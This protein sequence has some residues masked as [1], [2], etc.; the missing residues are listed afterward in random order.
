VSRDGRVSVP[1]SLWRL[2][3]AA[4]L[5]S[6][7]DAATLISVSISLAIWR[8]H[9]RLSLWEVGLLTAGL[10]LAVAVGSL[11]GG[12]LG[13]RLG[14]GRVFS[15]VLAVFVLGTVGI[16]TATDGTVLIC[17]VIVVGLAA[18]ADVPT[19]LAVIADAAPDGARGRLVAL[20]QVLWI[21]GVLV[22]FVLGFAVS[23]LGFLGTQILIGHLVLLAA[24]TLTLRLT[25]A[26]R[27]R[28]AGAPAHVPT[29]GS[30]RRLLGAGVLLP[31]LTTGT[32]FVFWNTASTTLGNYGTY[33][34]ITRTGLS[35]TEATG[36]VL[37]TFPPAL[38]LAIVFTR[39]ADSVWRDRLFVVAM[40]VQIAAFG[41]GAVTGGALLWGMAGLTVLYSL[42][43]VFA[44]EAAYKVWSQLLFPADVRSTALGL[45]YALARAVS[46]GFMVL[47]PALI[48]VAPAM[49]LWIL[50]ACVTVSGLTGLVITR[51]PALI[52]AL[53]TT[54]DHTALQ[55][56]VR[57]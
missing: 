40:L 13:D 14:R 8:D 21:A 34:L 53:P 30:A 39:L 29:A 32:F 22:T 26:A 42:S 19:S 4:G 2:A 55:S 20:T 33:F 31:L 54:P 38:V 46:A 5:A 11:V 1:P 17:G 24:V 56:D 23:T 18:G 52:R 50:T 15:Y 3:A 57:P 41:L 45:T 12:W 51:H 48:A 49:L 6:Y 7:L 44:G 43:N 35:Q 47:V 28:S 9:Y 37:L 36:M 25:L 27:A 16:I 10:A